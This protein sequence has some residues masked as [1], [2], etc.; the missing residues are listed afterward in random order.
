MAKVVEAWGIDIG[1]CALK[2]LRLH[3]DPDKA[4]RV[5]V[6][7]FD[8]IEYPRVLSQPEAD[9][10]ALLREALELF[11]S[12]NTVKGD[13]VAISVSGSS[14]LARFIKLP[15]VETKKIPDIVR[16]EA[17]QQIPFDLKDVIWD[18]QR[19]FGGSE[20]EG[21]ALETEVGLFAM[22][23]DQVYQA[24]EPFRAAGIPVDIVQL[25]PLALYN[26]L[27]FDRLGNL[28]NESE[29]DS[30]NP[31]ESLMALS[32]GTETTDLVITNGYRVW[33]R[34]IPIGG[35]H[36]TKA[37]TK[38]L[39]LTYS[40]AE[41]LKRNATQAEDPK[42]VY[43]AM[44][45]IFKDMLTEVQRSVGFFN[46]LDKTARIG[47]VVALG[48]SMKLPGLKRYLSQN[49]GFEVDE[50]ES[51][52]TMGGPS[53]V[54]A[55]AFRS[56]VLCFGV[57]FGLALQGVG[58]GKLATNL[59]PVEMIRE[60][61]I[62][63]KKPWALAAALMLAFAALVSFMLLWWPWSQIQVAKDKS[64]IEV[65]KRL[66]E[67]DTKSQDL[68][69]RFKTSQD[70]FNQLRTQGDDLV[71][72][73]DQRLAW[74]DMLSAV[75]QSL[76][77]DA[78]GK[79]PEELP[80]RRQIHV[81]DLQVQPFDNL[82]QWANGYVQ[83]RYNANKQP[84]P[85]G[86][87]GAP[88]GFPAP[89]PAAAPGGQPGMVRKFTSGP[90]S[91]PGYVVQL[92]GFHLHNNDRL[93]QGAQFLRSTLL[94]DLDTK[95]V[96]VPTADGKGTIEVPIRELGISYPV[97]FSESPQLVEVRVPNPKALFDPA[98]PDRVPD[99][100]APKTISLLKYDFVVQFAWQPRVPPTRAT[101]RLGAL[102][103]PASANAL[104]TDRR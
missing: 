33:Q 61:I 64:W 6:D 80:D 59:V 100:A 84:P 53:V 9:P 85:G 43:Q 8:Y 87:P 99:P 23:R 72:R 10:V 51:F 81:E 73:I 97:I 66:K 91:G 79:L 93:D 41:H 21:F 55:P 37:L 26:Y 71:K 1:Q 77:H 78:P 89:P 2:A 47:K 60:R 34:N 20:E 11:L 36:F 45:P 42:A 86:A 28:P 54:T 63:A 19:M 95:T 75:N 82:S 27:V 17:N 57:A 98:H 39:K 3:R 22:K 52:N 104:A 5:I 102:A 90:P 7:A 31:P 29:F 4:D 68:I 48:N 38:E 15:P 49:L 40:K 16:Y 44:R 12:R 24:L 46:S 25:T 92:R 70:K 35:S 76:P 30:E 14:G 32:I 74:P 62:L 101:G 103:A 83:A 96:K 56:N 18:Y 94:E 50:V 65:S 58:Q 13:R 88:G 67:V 69:N